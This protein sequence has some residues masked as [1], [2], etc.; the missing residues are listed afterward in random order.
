MKL[1][2]YKGKGL[3]GN[4]LVRWWKRSPYS[5]CELVI[6]G[7]CY[8]SS[9]MDGGVRSKWIDLADGKW[10]VIDLPWADEDGALDYFERTN[11]EKYSWSS[12]IWS[13]FFGR[14]TDEPKASFCSE[15]CAAALGLPTPVIYSPEAL[16][17]L[18]IYFG[19]RNA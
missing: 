7:I 3:I 19:N 9:V 11:G 2:L 18:C 16:G 5:H 12:L 6:G 15:W 14:E 8:S 10:D 1:A 4:A 17:K 13:Q